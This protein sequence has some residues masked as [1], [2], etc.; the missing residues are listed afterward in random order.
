MSLR[1]KELSFAGAVVGLDEVT[2]SDL[3]Q[4]SEALGSVSQSEPANK[5]LTSLI[6]W[7]QKTRVYVFVGDQYDK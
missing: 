3:Y 5:F 7:E 4:H 6:G 1:Q 2:G